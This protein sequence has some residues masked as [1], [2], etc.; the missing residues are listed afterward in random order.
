MSL[1]NSQNLYE[2][3]QKY[4]PAGVHS[5]V[6][7][8][9]SV[10]GSPIFFKRGNGSKL[11]DVDGNEY[12]DFCMSWGALL[13]GHA[14]QEVVKGVQEQ[15]QNGTHFGTPTELDVELSELILSKLKIFDKIRF[16]NSGT[17]AV[18][19]AIRLARGAT[20][21]EK[22]VKID[23]SY[24]GHS[25]SLLV[26]AGS[27]LMTQG[28]ASSKGVPKGTVN[29]TITIPSN[30]IE[31]L[32]EVFKTYKDQIAAV[33]VEPIM[34]NSGLFTPTKEWMKSCRELTK[35]NNA[36]L[37]FDEVITGFRVGPTG[38][39]GYFDVE[40]DIAT[41][42]K[43]IG[44]GLPVGAI[45]A[46][47]EIMNHIAPLG[48]VYQAGTLSGNPL[49]MISGI[50]T[51]K[52]AF[53]KDVYSY[54]ENELGPY[55]DEK[56]KSSSLP[57]HYTRIGSIF[58]MAPD[59]PEEPKSYHDISKSTVE[60]YKNSYHKLLEKG[61]Y[62]SPSVYEVAFLSLAHTKQDIDKLVNALKESL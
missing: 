21:R 59:M 31:A 15:V 43:I 47:D 12:V 4:A 7:A 44:G 41:Y 14:N 29:D 56:M 38:A 10:G 16:V 48:G 11:I 25:D 24:H 61:I 1:T 6:R 3:S 42:G 58:W 46:K 60:A 53:S 50:K 22:F 27:G 36:L 54:I 49:C 2:K 57:I 9:K 35:E 13:L 26:N 52:E 28:Q 37:I 51:L 62:L 19:T 17:E 33:I 45:C 5:P 8:F 20:G 18:M 40:P 55:L 39:I 23:G 30:N 34:A 32:Q